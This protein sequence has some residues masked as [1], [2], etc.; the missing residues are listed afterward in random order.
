MF[1]WINAC[2]LAIKF[3]K[4]CMKSVSGILRQLAS[5]VLI[6]YVYNSSRKQVC[7]PNSFY[8]LMHDKF[9]SRKV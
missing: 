9:I 8:S 1:E 4:S 2:K 5:E 3:K 7:I 6:G